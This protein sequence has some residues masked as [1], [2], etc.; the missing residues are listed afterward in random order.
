M[1]ESRCTSTITPYPSALATS[2]LDIM[3]IGGYPF[4]AGMEVFTTSG[5]KKLNALLPEATQWL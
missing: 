1:F 3:A 2:K 5:W 4:N